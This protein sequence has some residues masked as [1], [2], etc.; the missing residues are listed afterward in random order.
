[1]VDPHSDGRHDSSAVLLLQARGKGGPGPRTQTLAN[2]WLAAPH[3]RL[4]GPLRRVH[5][6]QGSYILTS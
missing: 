3:G 5:R 6:S 1:M 4:Q 2:P